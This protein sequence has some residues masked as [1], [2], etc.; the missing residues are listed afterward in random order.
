MSIKMKIV[1]MSL[2]FCII[3][4][5]PVYAGQDIL[6][7]A[8]SMPYAFNPG[9][10]AASIGFLSG[11]DD[12]TKITVVIADV[13]GDTVRTIDES[14]IGGG[15]FNVAW[16]GL[17]DRR[18]PV[19]EGFY[20]VTIYDVDYVIDMPQFLLVREPETLSN[21]AGLK[22]YPVCPATD[23]E[24]NIYVSDGRNDRIWKYDYYGNLLTGWGSAGNGNGQFNNPSGIALDSNGDVYV[25]D[26]LNHRVQKF[27][28]KGEYLLQWGTSGSGEGQFNCPSGISIDPSGRIYVAD[29]RNHRVQVFDGNG[30]FQCMWGS[31]GNG[32]GSFNG[33]SGIA[34]D[35][36]G[37]VLVA[38]TYNNRIQ[39]FDSAGGYLGEYD[40]FGGYPLDH[41]AGIAI[42]R[43]GRLLIEDNRNQRIL[44]AD[45]D[46]TIVGYEKARSATDASLSA[47]NGGKYAKDDGYVA[48]E[49][50]SGTGEHRYVYLPGSVISRAKVIVDRTPPVV[51]IIVPSNG[52]KYDQYSDLG[53]SWYAGDALSGLRSAT[54]TMSSGS[55]MDTSTPGTYEFTVRATDNAGNEVVQTSSYEIVSESRSAGNPGPVSS[56]APTPVPTG[57]PTVMPTA[58]PTATPA[59][60]AKPTA[61]PT[62][63]PDLNPPRPIGATVSLLKDGGSTA[64]SISAELATTSSEINLGLKY[65][66]SLSQSRGML[67]VF[68]GDQSHTFNMVDMNFPLDIIFIKS[69]MTILK[70]SANAQPGSTGISSGG[71]CK[72]VL[73][74]N[75]GLCASKGIH[76]GNK[77]KINWQ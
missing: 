13:S 61:S 54:G 74:V 5:G 41:P 53:A 42:N 20:D 68:G 11:D 56:P 27:S 28:G 18:R 76:A 7:D 64:A 34:V 40:S 10:G 29:T 22:Y 23:R 65:R 21:A 52:V 50:P 60:T 37:N 69:D 30:A 57:K 16:D 15:R 35:T 75:A 3:S 1:I 8:V 6:I 19:D 9:T 24:G 72:Y 4:S 66:P 17:D 39:L 32:P 12:G 44:E 77:V 33:P 31:F 43:D 14:L 49:K 63:V 55:I 47:A 38:D 2:V 51:S 73:E 26:T 67:F 46:R 58:K 62:P 48:R 36:T 25:V 70:I 59:P 71:A 45:T